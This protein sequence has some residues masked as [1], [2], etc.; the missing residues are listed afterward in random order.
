MSSQDTLSYS[1]AGVRTGHTGNSSQIYFTRDSRGSCYSR[2][3]TSVDSALTAYQ[4]G[5]A[6]HPDWS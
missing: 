5:A 4:D 2:A 1:T 6:C 3:P